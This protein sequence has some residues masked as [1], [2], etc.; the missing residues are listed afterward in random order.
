MNAPMS[1][2]KASKPAPSPFE[3]TW[4]CPT[5]H[6]QNLDDYQ[7]TTFPY[8]EVCQGDFFWDDVLEKDAMRDLNKLLA[9]ATTSPPT[10]VTP[11]ASEPDYQPGDRIELTP[12]A[13]EQ[14]RARQD[15]SAN[16]SRKAEH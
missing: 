15:S 4:V 2:K 7:L 6:T 12:T 14:E 8:C 10:P 3:V 5:C 11:D 9:A 1:K 13:Y 16:A